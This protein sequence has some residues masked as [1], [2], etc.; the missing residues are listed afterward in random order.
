MKR[1]HL[2]K[3]LI[4]HFFGVNFLVWCKDQEKGF[5]LA[6]GS[7]HNRSYLKERNK[8]KIYYKIRRQTNRKSKEN[9]CKPKGEKETN[10]NSREWWD[11][12]L[13]NKEIQRKTKT[14]SLRF[15]LFLWVG[16]ESKSYFLYTSKSLFLDLIW[17]DL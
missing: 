2:Q 13:E 4:D 3:D 6:A 17:S 12:C 1:T 15:E 8:I 5:L 11:T 16:T 10:E 7:M 9:T 14:I